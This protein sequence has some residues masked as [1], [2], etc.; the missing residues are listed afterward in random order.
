MIFSFASDDTLVIF[1]QNNSNG[2]EQP[3]YLFSRDLR[4][5]EVRYDIM[6][7]QYYSLVKYLNSFRVYVLYSKIISYV[8][9]SI[10]KEIMIQPDIDG[11]IS[12]WVSK[13]LEFDMEEKP[14][15]L[16]KGQGL[17]RLLAK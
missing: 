9:S 1:L 2:M 5:A 11:K 15:K 7:N 16:V 6:E 13:I 3:I 12:K 17:D 8:P 4:Y 10:V 14:T